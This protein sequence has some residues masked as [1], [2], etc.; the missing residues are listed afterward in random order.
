MSVFTS[1]AAAAVAPT[2]LPFQRAAA[3]KQ[4]IEMHPLPAATRSGEFLSTYVL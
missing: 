4:A 3:T 1:A 2:L